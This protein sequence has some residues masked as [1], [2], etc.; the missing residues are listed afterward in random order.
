MVALYI[1]SVVVGSGTFALFARH[2]LAQFG[3]ASGFESSVLLAGGLAAAF[4]ATQLMY[5]AAINLFNPTRSAGPYITEMLSHATA[6]TFVPFLMQVKVP[7]PHE[8]LEK[9]E[10]LV[11]LAGFGALH[12]LFKAMTFFATLQGVPG[13]RLRALGWAAAGVALGWTAYAAGAAWVRESNSLAPAAPGEIAASAAGDTIA[14]ARAVSEGAS[15]R[16]PLA[17][18]RPGES[19]ALRIAADPKVPASSAYVTI[20]ME[21]ESEHEY[22]RTTALYTSKWTEIRVPPEDVPPDCV[23]VVVRWMRERPPRWQRITRVDQLFYLP[24]EPGA[25]PPPLV[26]MSGPFVRRAASD[27]APTLVL[28]AAETL[29]FAPEDPTQALGAVTDGCFV[30]TNAFT[31]A[32]DGRASASLLSGLHPLEL[33]F[34]ADGDRLAA[35]TALAKAL[36]TSG[37]ATAL[38]RSGGP[39]K[40]ALL[41]SGYVVGG[42]ETITSKGTRSTGETLSEV[43]KWLEDHSGSPAFLTVFLGDVDAGGAEALAAF[44]RATRDSEAADHQYVIL[45]AL[46]G[47][48][49]AKTEDALAEPALHVP[50][51][52][53]APDLGRG[54]RPEL[55]S[56]ED[57]AA[58]IATMA[59]VQLD[60][61]I[62]GR[63]PLNA[64]AEKRPVSVLGNGEIVTLRTKEF[65]FT[66]RPGEAPTRLFRVG[67]GPDWWRMDVT[68]KYLDT[69]ERYR[70][71]LEGFAQTHR[72]ASMTE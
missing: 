35:K 65:R 9:A 3:L 66:L 25:G 41:P 58:M 38:E 67:E 22:A 2:V 6:L 15:L 14:A 61:P 20:T 70:K 63:D 52:V 1:V 44:L 4:A 7:W 32:L 11:Y 68:T 17:R 43:T 42:F 27:S 24:P 37:Y 5:M 62:A 26:Y 36:H 53:Y 51:V 48:L 45:T 57:V 31:P 60:G 30:F 64:L 8:A 29:P 72:P 12:V 19:I 46:R 49:S 16:A 69:V 21:G 33:V 23:A 28:I 71:E 54:K 50:L 56:L 59:K 55:V 18:T 10:P 39:S 47:A 34:D 40:L 13:G